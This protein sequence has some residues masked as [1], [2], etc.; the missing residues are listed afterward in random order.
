MRPSVA[1]ARR[2]AEYSR[3]TLGSQGSR[4]AYNERHPSA[5]AAEA[6][7]MYVSTC[8]ASVIGSAAQS[9]LPR[10]GNLKHVTIYT[11]K[12]CTTDQRSGAYA[13]RIVNRSVNA[14]DVLPVLAC[15][16]K[17]THCQRIPT[18]LCIGS[19]A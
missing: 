1:W 6:C 2:I 9:A 11:K 12:P 7:C 5:A 15:T 8:E 17:L 18:R 16:V 19:R 4:Y 14:E 3:K 13:G 10:C